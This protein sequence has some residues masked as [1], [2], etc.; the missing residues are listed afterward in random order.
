MGCRFFGACTS[1]AARIAAR[2]PPPT[3]LLT[4]CLR[5]R[6]TFA[7]RGPVW[8]LCTV[9]AISQWRSSPVPSPRTPV[10]SEYTL[11]RDPSCFDSTA[12]ASVSFAFQLLSDPSRD[13]S[14]RGTRSDLLVAHEKE[15]PVQIDVRVLILA[16]SQREVYGRPP[17]GRAFEAIPPP[18]TVGRI[19]RGG[20]RFTRGWSSPASQRLVPLPRSRPPIK[21]SGHFC[22]AS[23]PCGPG[24]EVQL[25]PRSR[26]ALS[27]AASRTAISDSAGTTSDVDPLCIATQKALVSR[28]G[29]AFPK[30]ALRRSLHPH[31]SLSRSE[32]VWG[33]SRACPPTGQR[34]T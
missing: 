16:I 8:R 34:H 33:V 27:C 9:P 4:P 28:A 10:M 1:A 19:K 3:W 20:M 12:H 26:C 2:P 11:P 13:T 24:G 15:K 18:S 5:P 23:H 22:A 14:Q 17:P 21:D 6:L 7:L 32:R 29:P 31:S 25:R 30:P